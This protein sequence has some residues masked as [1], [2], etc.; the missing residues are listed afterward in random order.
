VPDE[1]PVLTA[2]NDLGGSIALRQREMSLTL[3]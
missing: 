3:P 2:L 1:D